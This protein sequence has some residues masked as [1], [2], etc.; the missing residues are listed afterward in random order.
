[1]RFLLIVMLCLAAGTAFAE[2]VTFKYEP[3][4]NSGSGANGFQINAVN[5]SGKSKTCSV[6]CKV[7]FSSGSTKDFPYTGQSISSRTGTQY[8]AGESAVTGSPISKAE[9]STSS[10]E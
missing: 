8:V 10:C 2:D 6:T 1:M 4:G 5:T 9:I 3:Q 7:T